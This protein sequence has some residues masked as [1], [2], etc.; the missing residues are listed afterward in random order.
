MDWQ[1]DP[2]DP[3]GLRA[4]EQPGRTLWAADAA[5]IEPD[6]HSIPLDEFVQRHMDV[7]DAYEGEPGPRTGVHTFDSPRRLASP[8]HPEIRVLAVR[9]YGDL[10]RGGHECDVGMGIGGLVAELALL[11]ASGEVVSV[12]SNRAISQFGFDPRG[13]VILL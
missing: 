7:G 3:V 8:D 13:R 12:L 6:G 10:A 5:I 2:N 1:A 11:T 4:A 9:W